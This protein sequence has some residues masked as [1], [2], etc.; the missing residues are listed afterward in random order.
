MFLLFN[1]I[2]DLISQIC[3]VLVLGMCPGLAFF[4]AGLLRMK[5]TLSIISQILSGIVI[6]SVL[7]YESSCDR[8]LDSLG[9]ISPNSGT[10]LDT[11]WCTI[12]LTEN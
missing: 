10:S 12:Q 6:L 8:L 1:P 9:F 11:H 2:I 7:W 4:E 5:N 3:T